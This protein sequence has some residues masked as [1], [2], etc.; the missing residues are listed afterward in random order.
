MSQHVA[1]LYL[2]ALWALES[3]ENP[4]R[5]AQA[6]HSLR[7]LINAV[8]VSVGVDVRALD[9]RMGDRL[10][11]LRES[12]Q[13][14]MIRT[15]NF[16]GVVWS[17]EIDGPLARFLERAEAFFSWLEEHRPRRRAE[18]ADTL[19]RLDSSGRSL[20]PR[21]QDL[22]VQTWMEIRDYF[23]DVCH[24]RRSADRPE[25]DS[26]LEA[27]ELFLLDRLRPRTFEDF[28]DIDAV[29]TAA[30]GS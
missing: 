24:H 5:F 2:G 14:T 19:T 13:L 7:E 25:F 15:T 18:F 6:A 23:I 21:L 12:W 22:N 27:F 29:I 1:D 8:P 11:P 4:D 9:E 16:D 20:P 26:W 3:N 17:G 30:E 10:A 28:D